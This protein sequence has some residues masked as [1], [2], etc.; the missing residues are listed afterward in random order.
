MMPA[1]RLADAG[2]GRVAALGWLPSFRAMLAWDLVD[3]RMQVPVLILVQLLSGVGSVLGFGLFF[4]HIPERAALFVVTGLPVINLI[5]VGVVALPQNIASQ[6][7]AETYDYLASLPVRRLVRVATTYVTNIVIGLPAVI[8]TIAVGVARYHLHLA[9]SPE[10]V[11]AMLFVI[12]AGT[13]L[14]LALGHGVNRPTL[15]QSAS[16]LLIFAMFGF[17]PIMFPAAHL[18]RW[19]VEVNAVLPFESMATLVRAGLSTGLVSDVARAS[20]VVALWTLLSMV[21]VLWTMG[22]RK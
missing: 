3:L 5:V 10:I 2:G 8:V 19:L 22:R 9:V 11:P 14:G 4:P 21:V 1:R 7:L 16:Q 20:L 12:L 13:L 6:K 18:P 15:T 17:C